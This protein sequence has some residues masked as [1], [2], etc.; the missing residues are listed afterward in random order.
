MLRSIWLSVTNQSFIKNFFLLYQCDF[1]TKLI[2]GYVFMVQESYTSLNTIICS[3]LGSFWRGTLTKARSLFAC[4]FLQNLL[5]L[6]LVMW[7]GNVCEW[8]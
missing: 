5:Q 2:I 3:L 8:E 4:V 1:V 6:T 7:S